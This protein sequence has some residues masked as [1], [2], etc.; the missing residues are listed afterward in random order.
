MKIKSIML[1]AVT[2]LL[3]FSGMALASVV[4]VKEFNTGY[5]VPNESY[6]YS[7]PYY[8][9]H[10][11][12]WSWMHS[13]ISETVTSGATLY[14]S[15]WDVDAPSEVDNI[16]AYDAATSAWLLLGSLAGNDNAWGYTT[17]TLNSEL[18]DD[19]ASGL[20]VSI[21][22]DS[23]HNY[24]YWA[25]TLAK[26]VLTVN[27]G[28]VPEPEPGTVPEPSTMILL[29]CGLLGLAGIKKFKKQ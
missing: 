17:F 11:Q 15:A 21:D 1:L 2:L 28:T 27:G 26:S 5:F 4:D 9:W 23:T 24:D 8:R 22:I 18:Y 16:Y 6:T 20:K 19:I 29:G 12:D 7:S 25:V 14:V 3:G 10:N 13:G